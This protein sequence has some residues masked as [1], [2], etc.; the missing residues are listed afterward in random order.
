[1]SGKKAL[2]K[3]RRRKRRRRG[4]DEERGT[5]RMIGS[6][7]DASGL[8]GLQ[9]RV[10]NRAVQRLL[11]S[12]TSQDTSQSER[13]AVA[14]EVVEPGEGVQVPSGLNWVDAFPVSASL[15]DLRR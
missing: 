8:A 10:G 15:R 14:R 11:A 2:V 13:E 5:R 4:A 1:M 3:R 12:P 6:G 9:Q 7:V